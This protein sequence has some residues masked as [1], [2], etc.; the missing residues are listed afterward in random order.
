MLF[1]LVLLLQH[2]SQNFPSDLTYITLSISTIWTKFVIQQSVKC[3][4]IS[5]V[6]IAYSPTFYIF[7]IHQP[8]LGTGISDLWTLL[9]SQRRLH[10][11]LLCIFFLESF[12]CP[13]CLHSPFI[14]NVPLRIVFDT[15]TEKCPGFR[16]RLRS[17]FFSVSEP[18]YNLSFWLG[19]KQHPPLSDT[20][21]KQWDFVDNDTVRGVCLWAWIFQVLVIPTHS[22]QRSHVATT[23]PVVTYYIYR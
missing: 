2:L 10:S 18:K 19:I 16:S 1:I 15:T 7:L 13:P 3:F 21:Y 23:A 9:Q 22:L 6:C 11:Y 4:Y 20:W 5:P 14:Y 8:F 12:S 17:L